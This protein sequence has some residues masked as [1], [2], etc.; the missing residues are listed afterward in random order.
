[1]IQRAIPVGPK[2]TATDLFYRTLDLIGPI[3]L[4]ALAELASGRTDFPPQDRTKA[5]FFHKRSDEDIRID[6]SWSAEEL[7]RLVRAQSDPYPPAFCYH[8]QERL[9]ILAADVSAAVY[10]GTPGRIFY[11]EGLGV[12]IVAGADARRG[13]NRAL[14]ITNLRTAEGK[15]LAGV[16]YFTKMGGYLT[17]YPA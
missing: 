10:G 16:E 12:A 4:A 2:D 7:E 17:S 3:L 13:R 8:G 15:E 11:R 14:L 6:W 9:E 5:S 1:V